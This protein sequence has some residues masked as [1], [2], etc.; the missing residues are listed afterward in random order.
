MGLTNFV[1]Q[2]IL[3]LRRA[4]SEIPIAHADPHRVIMC[5]LHNRPC[6]SEM[7]SNNI[8]DIWSLNSLKVWEMTYSINLTL[9]VRLYG[10]YHGF[11][12]SPVT[13]FDK[14]RLLYLHPIINQPSLLVQDKRVASF[15]VL[16]TG[17]LQPSYY[18]YSKL[19]IYLVKYCKLFTSNMWYCDISFVL[20]TFLWF[21]TS[22]MWS[23][24]SYRSFLTYFIVNKSL[25]I[26][27]YIV[28][29]F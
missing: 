15:C 20:K 10:E 26:N 17:L 12:I 24:G 13:V 1:A 21:S 23:F 3:C 18:F 27:Y 5:S 2:A 11:P 4:W 19:D 25:M 22:N 8:Q 14:T 28:F 29:C 6:V 7:K 16:R 9:I